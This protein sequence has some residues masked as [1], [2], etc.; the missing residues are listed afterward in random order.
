[1]NVFT[2]FVT[3]TALAM[4]LNAAEP[5]H[6]AKIL[7]IT[8]V[9]QQTPQ[10][11][12]SGVK[13][14]NLKPRHWIEV[15]AEI[16]VETTD[17]SGFIPELETKWFAV[18]KDSN[19]K[20]SVRLTGSVKFKNIRARDK[21]AFVSVYIEPDTMERLTGKD[22]ASARDIEAFAL[23]ISGPSIIAEGKYAAGLEKATEKERSKWWKNWEGQTFENLI[24]AKSK[25]PFA[26]LW[27]DRYPTE[28]TKP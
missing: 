18:M 20:K 4:T 27:T 9:T 10:F 16:E 22:K 24:V 5:A 15:E 1:M 8:S 21:K 7:K 14:K 6:R 25:T 12:V 26:P 11:Q 19:S 23:V 3:M 2:Q 28:V 17:P 13:N